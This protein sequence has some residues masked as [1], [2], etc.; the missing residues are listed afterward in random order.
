MK[1]TTHSPART[2]APDR[3]PVGTCEVCGAIGYFRRNF[4]DP[5]SGER[6]RGMVMCKAH[7][8]KVT[9]YGH[10]YFDPGWLTEKQRAEIRKLYAGGSHSYRELAERF[11]VATMTIYRIVNGREET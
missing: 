2:M 1:T 6:V 5:D 4:T 9:R 10:P 11:E 7:S 3:K 8:E